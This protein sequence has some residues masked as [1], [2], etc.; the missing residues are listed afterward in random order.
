M[1]RRDILQRIAQIVLEH[2]EEGNRRN[3]DKAL[4]R[5]R[6]ASEIF[7]EIGE[8]QKVAVINEMIDEIESEL[9]KAGEA[10]ASPVVE[11]SVLQ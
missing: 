10:A 2:P 3:L 4:R 9:A 7:G 1:A 6:E 5:Y 11:S 8:T